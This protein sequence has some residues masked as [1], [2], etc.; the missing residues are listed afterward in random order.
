MN[1]VVKNILAVVGG[2][3]VG[4]FVN[5]GIVMLGPKLIPPPE[6]AVVTTV[7]GL[8]ASMHLME[9]KHF[10]MP[11]L[12]HALG[13]LVGAWIAYRYSTTNKM[14]AA[15]IVG[16]FFLLGGIAN[17]TMLPSPMWFNV[18]DLALAYI[19]MAWLATKLG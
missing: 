9:T 2:I 19:P 6:G 16:F 10:I 18:A 14:R 7:E 11:W 12:A 3:L 15:Y 1:P 13:T 5:M 4:M 8:K 17:V